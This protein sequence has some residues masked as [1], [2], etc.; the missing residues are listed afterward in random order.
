MKRKHCW[1]AAVITAIASVIITYGHEIGRYIAWGLIAIMYLLTYA[2][3]IPVKFIEWVSFHAPIGQMKLYTMEAKANTFQIVKLRDNK[4]GVKIVVDQMKNYD[5]HFPLVRVY[6]NYALDAVDSYQA[7]TLFYPDEDAPILSV[8][9][10]PFVDRTDYRGYFA[11]I[12]DSLHHGYF[13][14]FKTY[15]DKRAY[16]YSRQDSMV[17]WTFSPSFPDSC[18]YKFTITN[19]PPEATV[20][21]DYWSFD[22]DVL[23]K[24]L[25]V[26]F[27]YHQQPEYAD[28][29]RFVLSSGDCEVEYDGEFFRIEIK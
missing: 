24:F 27:Y 21:L 9:D 5:I 22:T 19:A 28:T 4:S 14:A 8:V 17:V 18:G 16:N 10:N 6:R 2:I 25:N 1:I 23:Q 12:A 3:F 26:V 20:T 29:K 11:L 13:R 7:K 15:S